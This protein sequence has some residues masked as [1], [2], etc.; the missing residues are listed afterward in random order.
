MLQEIVPPEKE[1]MMVPD[2]PDD[3]TEEDRQAWVDKAAQ[4]NT[5]VHSKVLMN[6][7]KAQERQVKQFEKRKN[8]GVKVFELTRGDLVL[9]RDMKNVG[10]K[11]DRMAPKWTGPYR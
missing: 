10:R 6:I 7:E 2:V 8:K 11:G 3:V 4:D 9:R 1:E 5:D